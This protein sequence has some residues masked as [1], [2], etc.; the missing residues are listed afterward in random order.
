MSLVRSS[1]VAGDGIG[2]AQTSQL[3]PFV[4]PMERSAEESDGSVQGEFILWYYNVSSGK[5][6]M[7]LWPEII[8]ELQLRLDYAEVPLSER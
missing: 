6:E 8:S 7:I 5:R 3:T 1:I 2:L 4:K